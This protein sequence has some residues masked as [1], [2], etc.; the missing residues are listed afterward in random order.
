AGLLP[1]IPVRATTVDPAQDT[2][3]GIPPEEAGEAGAFTLRVPVPAGLHQT[4]K[5]RLLVRAACGAEV[6]PAWP[7]PARAPADPTRPL[8]LFLH[9]HAG[10]REKIWPAGRFAAVVAGI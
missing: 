3:L 10:K 4:A 2:L 6:E 8:R 5:W 9:P 1:M 7:L